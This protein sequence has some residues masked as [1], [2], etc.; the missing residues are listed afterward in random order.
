MGCFPYLGFFNLNSAE[1]FAK[2]KQDE[3]FITWI[4]PV[5]A[6]S[7]LGYFTD[8]I[9]SS[10]FHY[11]DYELAELIFHELFHT[12]FFVKNDV[13]LNENLAMYFSKEMLEG[14]FK[15]VHREDYLRVHLKED[16]EDK[17]L[18]LLLVK[19][20]GELNE[21]YKNE[22]PTNPKDAEIVLNNFLEKK[23]KVEILKKCIDLNIEPKNCHP[24]DKKWN[25]A[26]FAAFLTYEKNS[27]EIEK[28]HKKLGIDLKNYLQY[29]EKKHEDFMKQNQVKDFSSYLLE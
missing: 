6:Y 9:L 19:L 23:F 15:S 22:H 1:E 24:L 2:R 27:D 21:I 11:K 25:N 17:E 28:L 12:I 29:I 26:R 16:N 3:Q 13:D 5:Y 10:F 7:T 4:R 20:V 14:Y 8:N 18:S